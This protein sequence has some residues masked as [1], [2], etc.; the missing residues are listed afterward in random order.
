MSG[1]HAEILLALFSLDYY[2]EAEAG[3]CH[4]VDRVFDCAGE[5]G[6]GADC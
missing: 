4:G 6:E 2:L 5:A 3:Y 1:G